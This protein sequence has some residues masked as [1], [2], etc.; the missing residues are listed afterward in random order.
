VRCFS[1]WRTGM[2]EASFDCYKYRQDTTIRHTHADQA[3]NARH[4]QGASS[5]YSGEDRCSRGCL[6]AV[7]E[8]GISTLLDDPFPDYQQSAPPSLQEL[9]A[10]EHSV[11]ATARCLALTSR[12]LCSSKVCWKYEKS[13]DWAGI[14]LN[15]YP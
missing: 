5:A 1:L 14:F 3:G 12:Q 6:A 9:C 7:D 10:I 4:A 2:L 13:L 8:T 15:M 11:R